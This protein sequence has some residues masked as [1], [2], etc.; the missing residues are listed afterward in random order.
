MDE[1]DKDVDEDGVVAADGKDL[2]NVTTTTT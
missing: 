2:D 1:D